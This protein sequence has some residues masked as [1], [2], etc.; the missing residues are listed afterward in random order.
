[1]SNLESFF[2]RHAKAFLLEFAIAVPV[3]FAVFA[4]TIW[5]AV[6]VEPGVE[7]Q[8]PQRYTVHFDGIDYQDLTRIGL[9][10]EFR[11]YKTKAGKRIEFHGN[12]Y[13]VEQ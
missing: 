4:L 1:V 13:E 11:V 9:S 2:A 6:L 12:F 7:P 3:V 5:V 8:A 10:S